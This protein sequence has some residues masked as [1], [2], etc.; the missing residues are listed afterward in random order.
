MKILFITE[1]DSI[2][3]VEYLK[4][5]FDLNDKSNQISILSLKNTEFVDFY[6]NNNIKVYTYYSEK[7]L[8]VQRWLFRYKQVQR[9]KKELGDCDVIQV[10]L[11]TLPALTMLKKLWSLSPKH[12]LTFWGSDILR[13]SDKTFGIY[14]KYFDKV[15]SIN[16]LTDNMYQR[17]IEKFGHQ[18]DDKT[19]VFD[20][21]CPM[22]GSIDEVRRTITKAECKEY[23]GISPDDYVVPIGYNSIP[24]QQHI[25][26]IEAIKD[27][28]SKLKDKITFILHFAYGIGDSTKYL[29]EVKNILD[30][31]GL[32]Y[33]VID[34]YLDKKETSILRL[35][36]DIFLYAQTT[37][38][39]SASVIEYL[40]SGCILVKP[41]WLNYP[42]LDS[43]GVKYISYSGFDTLHRAFEEAIGELKA[44]EQTDNKYSNN[45]DILWNMNSW[46]VVVP[47]WRALYEGQFRL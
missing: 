20:F 2:W 8:F 28:D 35:S 27:I 14:K 22:Y 39:L 43:R 19:T 7:K 10:N 41:D 46:E 40:Y 1:T 31:N 12:I 29:D 37:D 44:S 6:S 38:A 36:T 17:L 23:W 16:L 11:V 26:V 15:D 25:K 30:A 3:V 4:N 33:I 18:Y 24:E 45:R 9:I 47:K 5:V 34:R 32:K 21:G 42:E 13:V